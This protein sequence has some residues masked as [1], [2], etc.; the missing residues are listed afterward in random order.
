MCYYITILLYV[1]LYG[2]HACIQYSKWCLTIALYR[3]IINSHV[4][5]VGIYISQNC[6]I[7]KFQYV[8]CYIVIQVIDIY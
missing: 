5:Y 7:R 6:V 2:L 4:L 3:G 1:L 8:T